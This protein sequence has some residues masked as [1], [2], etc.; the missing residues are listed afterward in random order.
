M[1]GASFLI[2]SVTYLQLAE[3]DDLRKVEWEKRSIARVV[4]YRLIM[5]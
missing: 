5:K 2:E 4:L 3:I 1:F